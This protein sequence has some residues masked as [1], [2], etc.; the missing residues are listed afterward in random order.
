MPATR[1]TVALNAKQSQKAPLLIPASTSLSSIQEV[2]FKTAKT[3]LRLKKPTR[4]FV[5]GSG[6]ELLSE[7]DWAR[8]V[9]D[10]ITL[11]VSAGEEF[12]GV[13]KEGKQHVDSN[14]E[15]PVY[16]LAQKA[17]VDELSVTQVET[18][19]HTLP[20]IIHAVGQPDLHPGTKF[21]IGAVFVSRKW[22]HPPLIGSDI[23][24]GMAWYHTKLS[25]SQVDGDKG[26]KI[27]EKLRGLE[28]SWR[29]Q[30]D[31]EQWLLD[32][33][34][35]CSAG[36]QWDSALGTI[37]A[38]NHFAEIQVVESSSI[39][40][41]SEVEL[42]QDEVILLVHSGSRGYGSILKKYTSGSHI[43]LEEGSQQMQEYMEEHDK[44]CRWAKANRNL[45]AVR[46]LSC[47][48]PGEEAWELG[49]NTPQ[50]GFCDAD[51]ISYAKSKIAERQVVDILHNNVQRVK[52]PPAP[53]PPSAASMPALEVG[54]SNVALEP[55]E[56][57]VVEHV[58]IH[59]K[60][61]APTYDPG[62]NLPLAL[63]P[64]PGSRATPTIILKPQFTVASSW[65]L[66]NALSLAH[67]AGRS[68]SRAKALS[69]LSQKYRNQNLLEPGSGTGTWVI[70]DEKDLVFEEAPDA[71]K[72]VYAV[73]DDLVR[74]GVA[75][76]VGW[77]QTR[78][79]YK[80]RNEAR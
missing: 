27:A 24:C 18:T 42:K 41:G 8:H 2:V 31:R 34:G 13:R 50:T 3:K 79:S 9:C 57:A 10:D 12:V 66:K 69:S 76:V 1:V 20:G 19:A 5:G 23:G 56:T 48:E 16:I 11:L 54:L 71:Y 55:G 35:S 26:K 46:F 65:G 4:I 36:E 58:Y 67:G 75:E 37:G 77:C 29:K 63:L 15:C 44:A 43:S 78:V 40:P 53:P 51:A 73:S 7:E 49:R 45:I 32:R 64:L 47:L 74:E 33:A 52:W 39:P 62:T 68:M 14:A 72:D 28:G 38:G 25:R 61:A 6:Q 30:A 21:P 17:P 59:R 80:V 70:C 22:V 60:G